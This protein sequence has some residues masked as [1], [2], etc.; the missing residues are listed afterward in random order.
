MISIEE[1]TQE[2]A[3]RIK[4]ERE[5]QRLS[6]MALANEADN[7]QSFLASLESG[8]KIPTVTTILKIARALGISPALFFDDEYENKERVKEEIINRIRY[9]L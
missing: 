6:Q 5:N 7:S 4:K 3:F 9:E 2:V 8:K 1:K